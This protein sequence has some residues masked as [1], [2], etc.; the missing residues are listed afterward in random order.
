MGRAA[1]AGPPTRAIAQ[2]KQLANA[3]QDSDRAP[4]FA[5]EAAAQEIDMTTRAAHEGVAAF[6]ERRAPE[7]RGR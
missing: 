3:A 5:A 6:V 1:G 2:T 4:V 7:C